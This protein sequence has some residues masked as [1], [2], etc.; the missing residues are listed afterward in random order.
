M[1]D[2]SD[3]FAVSSENLP[4][5][6]IGNNS[7]R[8]LQGEVVAHPL[9]GSFGAQFDAVSLALN[10]QNQLAIMESSDVKPLFL[11]ANFEGFL[12]GNHLSWVP[13]FQHQMSQG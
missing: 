2:F 3:F 11:V 13:V 1:R 8:R 12:N 4:V 7:E 9:I 10:Y 5:L 6:A